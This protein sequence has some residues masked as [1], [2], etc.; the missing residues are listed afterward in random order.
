[1]RP[2]ARERGIVAVLAMMFIVIFSALAA[3]MAIVSQGNLRT[4]DSFQHVNRSL[5]A[6]ETGMY[7]FNYRLSNIAS[8]IT[9]SKGQV[10][11]TLANQ[12]WPLL[13]DAIVAQ[14]GNELHSL[15]PASMSSEKVSLGRIRLGNGAYDPT[16]AITIERHP[17]AGEDYGSAFYSRAPFNQNDGANPYTANGLAVGSSNAVANWWVRIRSVGVDGTYS[18][19]IQ[20]DFRI[21]KK[22]RFAMLSRSRVMLGRNVLVKGPI[23]SRYTDVTAQNGHPVQS[24]DNYTGLDPTLDGWIASLTTYL[25]AHDV[26]GDNRINLADAREASALDNAASYD[27]NHD[28]YVDAYDM[29]LMKYDKDNKGYLAA[30]DFTGSGG[31]MV[32]AQLWRLLNEAKYPADTQ[33]DWTNL[34]VKE[35][36]G[37]WKDAS[38][39]LNTIDDN[40]MTDKIRG[41]VM[42]TAGKAAW[43]AG[44]ANGAYQQQLQGSLSPD[45]NQAPITFNASDSQIPTLGPNDFDTSPYKALATGNFSSQVASNVAT[46]GTYAAPSAATLEGVPY[47]SP[48]P[49]DY[50]QR[51]VYQNMTFTDVTIPKGTNALFVNCTFVGVTYVDTEVNNTDSAFNYAGALESSGAVKYSGIAANVNGANVSDTK[52]LSNNLRFDGCTFQG[53]IASATPTSYT[54]A[55]NKIS[56]TGTTNFD[57]AAPNLSATQKALFAKSTLLTPQYSID[58]G[59]FTDPTSTSQSTKLDGTIVAGVLDIRGQATIDG[60]IITTF[61][62]VAGQGPLAQGGNPANFNTTIGYFESTAGD[63]EAELP[64]GGGRGKIIIR[65]NPNRALPDGINGPIEVRMDN[66]TYVEA[67]Q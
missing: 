36:G 53:M 38:A 8:T 63:A 20:A 29:F 10:D 60:T 44:A 62:P 14:M 43:Q 50:Y 59:T 48:Y 9:T 34:K 2:A 45:P 24:R 49:Y 30:A 6:A 21:D 64:T 12:L 33:F 40:D 56:F 37:D 25:G 51:P 27:R 55:R 65:Y 13:R 41:Q 4:A 26:D 7:F 54:H 35:P 22:V 1:V 28:G 57:I 5:S 32:D 39:D 47:G 61:E 15:E 3:A 16:M 58:M 23:G 31:A 17:I 66:A 19:A 18:R 67:G 52:T 46:G 42:M 11:S